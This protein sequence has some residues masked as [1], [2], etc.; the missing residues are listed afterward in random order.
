[1]L[2]FIDLQAQYSRLQDEMEQ[3]VLRVLRGGKYIMGP[4]IAELEIQLA[5]FAGVSHCI[6]CA[7]GTDALVMSLMAKGVGP[8][9][10]VF[11]PPFTFVATAESIATV[12]AT[13]I[14]VD[15]DPATFNL[16]PKRL[17]EAIG[18][19]KEAGALMPGAVIAVDLFGLPADYQGINST[20]ARHGMFVIEDAAQSFGAR[21]GNRRAG[22]LAEIGCTSFFPAKPL[23]CY[24][25][26]GAIFT[27]DA[28]LAE[29]LRSIR[30][31]G[32][33]SHKYDN[34]RL[35]ITGRL[36]TIQAAVLLVKLQIFEKELTDRQRVA[37]LYA[38]AIRDAGL[39][40]ELPRSPEGMTSAYAQF[41]LLAD[42]DADRAEFLDRL[43][44][45]GIPTAIY[46]PKPLHL[47]P[48]FAYLGHKQG[49]FPVSEDLS[50]RIFSL[51]MHP[52]LDEQAIGSIVA[53]LA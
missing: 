34:V 1:M 28:D 19:V 11:V 38:R 51:P 17:E 7:S 31:H 13:P 14:F 22:A 32:Q 53:A 44:A 3:A 43:A 29:I 39:R 33:G 35:G 8:G 40:L 42:N 46:Y 16:S 48:A 24:G 52:Y 20:A 6:S 23:G 37:A 26:G 47:Q 27:D 45:R 5:R 49:D 18:R 21:A 2:Q 25:D 50:S 41:S 36:D 15:V 12:G 30:V 4:E 9:D 10:A